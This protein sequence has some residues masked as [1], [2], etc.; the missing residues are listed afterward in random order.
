VTATVDVIVGKD[1]R[2]LDDELKQHKLAPMPQISALDRG[3]DA[4]DA[5]ALHCVA[6]GGREC[7]DDQT[8]AAA[9]QE[10]D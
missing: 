5:L 3:R 7:A 1:A 2:T 8:A 10:R 6:T 4:L 9:S